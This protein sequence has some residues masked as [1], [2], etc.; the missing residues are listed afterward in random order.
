MGKK[1]ESPDVVQLGF[2]GAGNMAEALARG[3]LRADLLRPRDMLA[4]DPDAG[5][6]RLFEREL[7]VPAL[8]DNRALVERSPVVVVAVKPQVFDKAVAPLG[9]LFG[10]KKLLISICAGV[11]T[12]HVEEVAATGT[13]VVRAM[14]NTPML[15]GRGMAAVC[16]GKHATDTDLAKAQRLLG[17]AAQVIRVPEDLMDA[18]TAVSGSGPAYFFYLAEK[19]AAAGVELGLADEDAR[20]LSRVTFEGAAKLLAE[21]ADQ[22]EELRRRVTSPGGTTEAA[23]KTL[24]AMNF[25]PTVSAA[26]KAARDRAGELGR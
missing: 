7:K 6:R 1:P 3:V 23:I 18:V 17:A 21:S 15:V 5:R 11:S 13:R 10:P 14:P 19:L 2:L 12:A 4:S 26:V 9:S 22:P 8:E 25:G 16:G 24:D 20:L